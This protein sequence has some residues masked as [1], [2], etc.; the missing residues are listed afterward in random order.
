MLLNIIFVAQA[1]WSGYEPPR[2]QCQ[3]REVEAW[4]K[5]NRLIFYCA[6]TLPSRITSGITAVLVRKRDIL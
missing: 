1:K 6:R 3:I 4:G 2:Q 5:E